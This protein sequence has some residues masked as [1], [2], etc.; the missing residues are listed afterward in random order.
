MANNF[1]QDGDVIQY[2]NSGSAIAAGAIVLMGSIAGVAQAAI[3]SGATGPVKRTGVFRMPKYAAAGKT[4]AQG[5]KV[6][7]D[8]SNSAFSQEA[9]ATGDISGAFI[10][11]EAAAAT[12]A[13]GLVLFLPAIVTVT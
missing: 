9:A 10:A 7:W 11:A 13:T 5:D 8:V 3:A 4:W 6:L 2:T 1:H 12:D